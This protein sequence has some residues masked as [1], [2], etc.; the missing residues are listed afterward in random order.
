M[1]QFEEKTELDIAKEKAPKQLTDL[2]NLRHYDCKKWFVG[3]IPK[4]Y[5]RIT[6]DDDKAKEVAVKGFVEIY[7]EFGIKLFYTQSLLA[8][9]ILNGLYNEYVVVLSSQV[10]KLIADDTPVLTRYGWKNHGDL[11][12]G[13]E[14]I[15]PNGEFVKVTYVHPKGYANKKI[16]F[17]NGE[18]IKC[19][20]NHEWFIYNRHK[21]KNETVETKGIER[22]IT[23]KTCG[24]TNMHL[25]PK[26]ESIKGERRELNVDPYV[27]G[28]WLGDGSTTKG[29]IC[30]SK[31]DIAVLD[32]CREHYPNGAEWVHK[33]TSVITRSFIG[34]A[35]DL[36]YYSLC[37]QKKKQGKYIPE[38]YLTASEA[39]RLELLAGLIDTDGY[40]CID[41]RWNKERYEFTTSS[42]KLRDT[43][44]E[45]IHTFGWNACVV[46]KKPKVSSSGIVGK[47]TYWVIS[48]SADKYIPCV[49]E[50][51]RNKTLSR[52][53]R[54]GIKKIEDI[55][56]VQGN[57]ITVEGGLYLVGKTMITTHNSFL[58]GRIAL[59]LAHRGEPVY[60]ACANNND[61]E[62][63]MGHVLQAITE[64]TPKLKSDLLMQRDKINKLRSS[65]SK[66]RVAF[67][68]GGFVE[69]LTL[70]DTYNSLNRNQAIGRSGIYFVDECAKISADALSELGR[71]Q[72]SNVDGKPYPTIWISNPHNPGLFYDKLTEENTPNDRLTIWSDALSHIEEERFN[73]LQVL[74]SDFTRNKSTMR[75]YLLCELDTTGEGMFEQP[76]VIDTPP[77]ENEFSQYFLGLDA[78][79]KG[80]DSTCI[81]V[82]SVDEFG[83]FSVEEIT[84][85]DRKYWVDGKTNID[86]INDIVYVC[87]RKNIQLVCVDVGWG[88]WLIQGLEQAGINVKGVNFGGGVTKERQRAKH[89]SAVEGANMRAEM[90][91][92]LQDLIENNKITFHKDT[93]DKIKDAL[94]LITAERKPNGKIQI[95]PKSEIKAVLGKSPDELDAVL[96]AIHSAITWYGEGLD[97]VN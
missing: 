11:E 24:D 34:L 7:K 70:G 31:Q 65:L 81:S 36:G 73:E 68:N 25:I 22:E 14:V 23:H 28:V 84:N 8:G 16:T 51:K 49:L 75:R 92:D 53:R 35:S 71:R 3:K 56:P 46:E 96:L 47:H 72:F 88:V 45:L 89:H 15:S 9:A 91:L 38:E 10:G 67:A 13:D 94:P 58:M 66:T 69:C 17:Q 40:K 29:Q 74:T 87:R 82:V 61:T 21:G 83:N 54:I 19:H 85:L 80:K 57:C 4:H 39:Q 50:R 6:I 63:I 78:S 33:D 64:S 76:K 79:Y 77:K 27:F 20:E 37:N 48:F 44:K 5:K 86:I 60:I 93:Y 12:I 55:T 52:I 26:R 62:I 95:R 90:H 41:G 1:Q 42:P 32:K 97:F 59:K 30:S 43:F 2:L 18:E